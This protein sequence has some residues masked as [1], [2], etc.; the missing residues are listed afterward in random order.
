MLGPS[1]GVS[2]TATPIFDPH[3]ELMPGDSIANQ[4]HRQAK[5]FRFLIPTFV[6][7]EEHVLEGDPCSLLQHL[8][9]AE[10]AAGIYFKA[11]IED[12]ESALQLGALIGGWYVQHLEEVASE[13]G[14]ARARGDGQSDAAGASGLGQRLKNGG[15]VS[16]KAEDLTKTV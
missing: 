14:G 2:P 8:H 6:V 1:S 12:V 10:L 5:P 15:N 7:K 3:F 11:G 13:A 9:M 4:T 16:V